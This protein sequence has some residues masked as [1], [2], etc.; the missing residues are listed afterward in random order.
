[1]AWLEGG[2]PGILE[3]RLSLDLDLSWRSRL[4]PVLWSMPSAALL[5]AECGGGGWRGGGML[6]LRL[7][8]EEV[9]VRDGTG[10][11]GR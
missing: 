1:M 2:G 3:T 6:E 10:S 9:G 5:E 7:A 8:E 11:E 4:E